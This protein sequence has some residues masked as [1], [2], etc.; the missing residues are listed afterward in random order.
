[1]PLGLGIIGLYFILSKKID[2]NYTISLLITTFLFMVYYLT[3]RSG[4]YLT[5]N[6]I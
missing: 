2:F 1:M 5:S 4:K 3:I 6:E